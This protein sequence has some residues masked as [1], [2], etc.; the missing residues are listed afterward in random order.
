MRALCELLA[1]LFGRRAP[2]PVE[3]EAEERELQGIRTDHWRATS[4]VST[5]EK[6]LRLVEAEIRKGLRRG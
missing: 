5:L 2:G 1:R 4:R 6:E 3:L